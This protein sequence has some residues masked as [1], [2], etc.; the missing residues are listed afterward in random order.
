MA[1]QLMAESGSAESIFSVMAAGVSM[2]ANG[3][4]AMA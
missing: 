2:A 4:M 3:V 1:Y